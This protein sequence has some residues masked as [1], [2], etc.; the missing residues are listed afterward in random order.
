MMSCFKYELTGVAYYS[1]QL[2]NDAFGK[3]MCV[4]LA[5]FCPYKGGASKK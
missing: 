4:N 2:D 5:L 1:K 3:H